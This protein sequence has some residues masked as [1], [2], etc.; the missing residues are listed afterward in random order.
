MSNPDKSIDPRLLASAEAEFNQNGFIKAELKTICENAG[1]TTGALY[2]RY[3][4][5]EELFSAVVEGIVFELTDF[6]DSRSNIDFSALSDDEIIASWTMTY[7][8]FIPMFRLLYDNKTTFV[9]LI[10]KAAGT[11]YENFNHEFV[12]KLSYAY[13]KF[14]D[15]A[16][17]R[18]LAKAD[19]TRKEFHVLISSY[20]TCVCEPFIHKMSWKKIEEHC[21]VMCRFFNWRDVILL[22]GEDDV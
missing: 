19:V 22:K 11:R 14:Y 16:K 18:G 1:I 12:T 2:K 7:E 9:L 3:K 4:G 5:K 10:D 15:E 13:E 6:V 20:W 17:K 8:S 21:R